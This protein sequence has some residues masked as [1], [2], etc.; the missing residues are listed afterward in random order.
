MGIVPFCQ[1]VAHRGLG[2]GVCVLLGVGTGHQPSCLLPV[3]LTVYTF[4]KSSEICASALRWSWLPSVLCCAI[5]WGMWSWLGIQLCEF[6]QGSKWLFFMS[7]SSGVIKP[8]LSPTSLYHPVCFSCTTL[9]IFC[10]CCTCSWQKN[11]KKQKSR[12]K[13]ITHLPTNRREFNM[14]DVPL[15]LLKCKP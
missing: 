7:C 4:E 2:P 1:P 12:T 14:V 15:H 11:V 5:P 3:I 10:A 13:Q 8:A 6:R 9:K